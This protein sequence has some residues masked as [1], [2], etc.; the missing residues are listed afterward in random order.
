MGKVALSADDL[1]T[2]DAV[3]MVQYMGESLLEIPTSTRNLIGAYLMYNGQAIIKANGQPLWQQ[4]ISVGQALSK[5]LGFSPK[6]VSD[7]Y[8]AQ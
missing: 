7:Y 5:A 4:D 8:E 2:Q 6:S 3:N 1:T